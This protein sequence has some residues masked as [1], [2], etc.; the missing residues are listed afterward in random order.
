MIMDQFGGFFDFSKPFERKTLPSGACDGRMGNT[1]QAKFVD[2]TPARKVSDYAEQYIENER[3]LNA[4]CKQANF[5][6]L[7]FTFI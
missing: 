5:L 1:S 6:K 2:A 3:K 7:L 4:V